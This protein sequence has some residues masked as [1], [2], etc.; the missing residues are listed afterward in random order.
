MSKMPS[1]IKE[2]R[3]ELKNGR[4]IEIQGK[5]FFKPFSGY[6]IS[7]QYFI[8][9]ALSQREKEVKEELRK[10]IEGM[11][12]DFEPASS[13]AKAADLDPGVAYELGRYDE[14]KS[15]IDSILYLISEE[16]KNQP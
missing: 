13:W 14:H 4:V 9:T 7:L 1:K 5:K 3:I 10:K 12:K 8:E 6:V 16:W 15:L 2:W 11:K